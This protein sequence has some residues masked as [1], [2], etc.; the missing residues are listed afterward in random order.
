MTETSIMYAETSSDPRDYT[1]ADWARYFGGIVSSG[2]VDASLNELQVSA[3]GS[4]MTVSVATGSAWV[5]GRFM[6]SDAAELLVIGAADASWN[7]IDRVVVRNTYATGI[8]L[9][10]LT[11]TKAASPSA[12]A[13]TTT[14]YTKYEISLAQVLVE[15]G[16]TVIAADKVTDERTFASLKYIRSTALIADASL[17]LGA[18]KI[19]TLGDGTASTHAMNKGQFDD[20]ANF[21]IAP[22]GVVRAFGTATIPGG[23]LLCDGS[24]VSR[25][26]YA[27]LF[28]VIGTKF[29]SG[30]GTTTFN[31]PSMDNH[32]IIGQDE[33]DADFDTVGETGGAATV[34]LTEA[35]LPAHTHG[36]V[37]Y[38]TSLSTFASG[39]S[40]GVL[41][42]TL[43]GTSDPSGSGSA[44]DNLPPYMKLA[45]GIRI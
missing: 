5:N 28:G 1:A 24:A 43:S 31:L 45:W 16:A 25:T 7:R 14:G 2:V 15:A 26:T 30:D 18:Q 39:A 27:R 32:F 17:N 21:S 12:P 29:G 13:L 34:T 44:H 6:T 23:W 41:S 19:T 40:G 3:D 42:P 38:L 10:V 37:K 33:E 20:S 35:N 36:G 8:T 4:G 22:T 11:G 9:A